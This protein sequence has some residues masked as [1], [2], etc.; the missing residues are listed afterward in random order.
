MLVLVMLCGPTVRID[1]I[2]ASVPTWL[3][4]VFVCLHLTVLVVVVTLVVRRVRMVA[5]PFRRNC[6]VLSIRVWHVLRLTWFM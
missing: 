5:D 6:L 4:R 3:C 2:V 1:R